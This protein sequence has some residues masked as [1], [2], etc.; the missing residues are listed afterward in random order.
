MQDVLSVYSASALIHTGKGKLFGFVIS[1]SST[2][3]ALA[4]FYDNTSAAGTKLLE[5]HVASPDPVII[6]FSES[7]GPVFNIGLYLALAANLTAT[8]WSRQ[9]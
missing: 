3:A 9:V 6:F 5:V 7:F 8:V 2:T 1:C 4:T